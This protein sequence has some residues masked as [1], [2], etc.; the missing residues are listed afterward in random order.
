MWS[1]PRNIST[2][3]LRSFS[4]RQD[5][6]VYDEPFYS[7]YLKETNA[8]H[9]MSKEIIKTYP[10]VEKDILKLILKKTHRLF[11]Q[12]HMTHHILD[13]TDITWLKYGYNCFLIRH[14]KKVISSYIK[15]NKLKNMRDIGF[16]QQY[17]LFNYVRNNI[18]KN[19]LVIDADKLLKN[20]ETYLRKLCKKL[21]IDFT[22]KMLNWKKGNTKNFGIWYKHWYSEVIKSSGFKKLEN[23]NFEIPIKYKKIYNES[24]KI[25]KIMNKYSI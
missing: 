3:L 17:K 18:S 5:T 25:Y 8:N 20:P 4:N 11:Y 21:D 12:K 2:T 13:K 16:E 6:S 23:K 24:L 7:Y 22:I 15:K 9:P 19:V 14:P 1:G 10:Y